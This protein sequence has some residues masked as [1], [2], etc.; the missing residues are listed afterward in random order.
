MRCDFPVELT[1]G[2]LLIQASIVLDNLPLPNI[3]KQENFL[4]RGKLDVGF[5]SYWKILLVGREIV[6]E[7]VISGLYDKIVKDHMY[8]QNSI[9][10]S[11]T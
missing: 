5:F 10:L 8:V 9:T 6:S 2:M 7:V 1:L 4:T 3:G 11:Y